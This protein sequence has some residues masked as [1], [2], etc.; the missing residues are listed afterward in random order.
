MLDFYFF[1]GVTF[2][3]SNLPLFHIYLFCGTKVRCFIHPYTNNLGIIYGKISLFPCETTKNT[4]ILQTNYA[5]IIHD[6]I[7]ITR[8]CRPLKNCCYSPLSK[9]TL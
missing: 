4:V 5:S 6:N 3:P 2:S 7:N 8:Q 9:P 1:T